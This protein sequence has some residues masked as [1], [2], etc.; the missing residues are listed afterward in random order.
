MVFAAF[1]FVC[2]SFPLHIHVAADE[3]WKEFWL[4]RGTVSG[5][6]RVWHLSSYH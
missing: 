2:V 4:R 1:F 5:E 6:M 3:K